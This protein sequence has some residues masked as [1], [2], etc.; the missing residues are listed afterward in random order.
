[1]EQGAAKTLPSGFTVEW[2]DIAYQEQKAAGQ[3]TVVVGFA[4]L[5]AYLF[6]VALYAGPFRCRYCC[7]SP[8]G[9]PAPTPAWC[10]LG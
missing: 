10:W 6:L 8:S 5:F 7:P 2:T 4:M 1:M 9:W 3:T